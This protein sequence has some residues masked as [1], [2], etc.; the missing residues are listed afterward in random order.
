MR[1]RKI[2][3]VVASRANYGRIKSVLRAI[4]AHDELELQLIVSAS[5]LLY[6]FGN[7]IDVIRADG[8]EPDAMIYHVVE[9]E[10]LAT[11]AKSTGLAM[12]ELSTVFANLSPDLVVTVA[13]RHETIAT[14]ITA[15]Y[16]NIPVAHT[17]GGEVSGSIDENV[18]HAVTKLAHLHF[19]AS[20]LA[21]RNVIRMGEDPARV[22]MTGCPALDLIR[23]IRETINQPPKHIPGVGAVIDPEKPYLVVLQHPVTT[24][25]GAGLD[26]IA[27]TVRA[28]DALAIQTVW[29]WP[30]IDAG[31]DDISKGLRLYRENKNPDFVHFTRNF[32]PEDY[33]RLINNAACLIG[34][35]SSG[36][37]EAAFLG[38]PSVNIGSRQRLRERGANVMDVDYHDDAIVAAVRTQIGHG[39]YQADH[40]FGD[41]TAG[42]RIADILADTD[43]RI[44]K[45]LHYDA[46]LDTSAESKTA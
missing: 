25:Y 7:A 39:R 14:A 12:V 40:R 29:L 43:L 24:E 46:V 5:A 9:G 8:F 23:N 26:Q 34:N 38:T 1:K 44:D 32:T 33:A 19:P 4:E 36:I 22:F 13:D 16:M 18:R 21:A 35:S 42:R 37:R 45:V 20:E 30:N 15:S 28:I 31:S 10:N 17:Q 2:C 6:R 11:M 41:G 27:H 3:V